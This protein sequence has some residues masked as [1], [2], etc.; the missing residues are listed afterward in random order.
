VTTR[1]AF[2]E[3]TSLG[4]AALL[5]DIGPDAVAAS[6]ATTFRPTAFLRIEV[7]GTTTLFVD[8]AEMGQGVR[9]SLAMILAEEL[10]ADWS[11]VRIESATP[12]PDFPDMHTAGSGS[13]SDG[14][15]GLRTAGA[16]ARA[17]LVAAAA[18]QWKVPRAECR[19]E[20]GAVFH[21][22]TKRRL[23]YGALVARA[24]TLPVPKDPPLKKEV[25]FRLVGKPQRRVDGPTLADLFARGV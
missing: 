3:A 6:P 16:A 25:D 5:L 23:D 15:R 14:W 19:T 2:L 17:M 11:R 21:A 4:G 9:T 20:S 24:A 1:R 13:V 7:D 18:E 22:L 12:G 8:K 10:D